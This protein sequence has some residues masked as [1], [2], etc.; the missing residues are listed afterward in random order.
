MVG[1]KHRLSPIPASR[2]L[3]IPW[4]QVGAPGRGREAVK[5][6]AGKAPA[7]CRGLQ[8]QMFKPRVT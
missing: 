1:E 2:E 5:A 6:A 8:E 4:D 7:L 3:E